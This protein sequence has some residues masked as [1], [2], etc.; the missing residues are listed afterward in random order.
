MDLVTSLFQLYT[1]PRRIPHAA[2]ARTNYNIIQQTLILRVLLEG[3]NLQS[4]FPHGSTVRRAIAMIVKPSR[5]RARYRN[6]LIKRGRKRLETYVEYERP[7]KRF[8]WGERERERVSREIIES[9]AKREP[10]WKRTAWNKSKKRSEMMKKRRL[11]D[12]G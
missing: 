10:A 5:V 6:H 2:P 3:K 12:A 1:D 4:E 7:E 11:P 8:S 9:P